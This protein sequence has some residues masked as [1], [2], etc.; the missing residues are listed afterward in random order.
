MGDTGA[1]TQDTHKRA[2]RG[3]QTP[4]RPGGRTKRQKPNDTQKGQKEKKPE[5]SAFCANRLKD[6]FFSDYCLLGFDDS[7]PCLA[8][9]RKKV[10]RVFFCFV[11]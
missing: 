2:K 9:H 3:I 1:P 11:F 5:R 10:L 6:V 7:P 4:L 8:P